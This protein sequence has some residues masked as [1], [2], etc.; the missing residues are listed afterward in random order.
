MRKRTKRPGRGTKGA[1]N[2]LLS[3][4]DQGKAYAIQAFVVMPEVTIFDDAGKIDR[5]YIPD[6]G[7]RRLEIAVHES[8]FGDTL[9]VLMEKMG[10]RMRQE[11]GGR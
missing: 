8:K 9:P 10:L 6:G 2:P 4:E 5:R 7:G 1:T 11:K 3:Q